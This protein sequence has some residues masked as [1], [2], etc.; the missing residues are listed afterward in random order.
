MTI[1]V[2]SAVGRRGVGWFGSLPLEEDSR[3][4]T[5]RQFLV[6]DCDDVKLQD[7]VYLAGLAAVIFRQN[8]EKPLQIERSLSD[9]AQRLLD[10]D[11]RVI[12]R[13]SEAG[14]TILENIVGKLRLPTAGLR[15]L[16]SGDPPLPHIRVFSGSVPWTYVA[17]FLLMYPPG[18]PPNP[19]LKIEP[20][21]IQQKLAGPR[22]IL[23][24][25]AFYDCSEIYLTPME[26][27]RSAGVTV[28][29]AHA[30]LAEGLEG[31][32][33]VPLFIKIGKRRKIF[34]EYQNYEGRVVPYIP[35]H[36]GPHLVR[37]RCCLGAN[38][39][40]IVGDFVD[41]SECLTDCAREGR[42][43]SAI[44]CLFDRTLAGWH[45]RARKEE[46]S[47][48]TLLA[49]IFPTSIPSARF[50]FAKALGA[51]QQ[52]PQLR[53]LFDRCTS[54][55]VLVGPVHGD[56]H[57]RNVR[58]RA[59]DAIVIDFFAHRDCPL[60]FDA[61]S[62]EASLLVE[63]FGKAKHDVN[64]WMKSV[65]ALY[66]QYPLEA[67]TPHPNPK[68]SSAWFYSCVRQI[69]RHAHQWEIHKRQ[70]AGALAAALLSKAAKDGNA[71]DPEGSRRAAAYVFAERILIAAFGQQ[72]ASVAPAAASADQVAPVAPAAPGGDQAPPAVPKTTSGQ[73]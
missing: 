40:V 50:A 12:I 72:G 33:P 38:V 11:C 56:L 28:Y 39:G 65:E 71:A 58:V 41:E 32:W 66:E 1:S 44:A 19:N 31:Q 27:G 34:A 14:L 25:R 53:G 55:P 18:A 2:L 52:L 48:A 24:R 7:A 59:T 22:D 47:I 57:A 61:A 46:S 36:L 21:A 9:H 63:G 20:P 8:P 17:D 37:D 43:S 45:R 51:T 26:G 5:E 4:F 69:R 10:H 60:L 70:Y 49:Q 54:A 64:E 6:S 23:L 30:E 68:N 16:P 42:A 73:P 62:L 3:A 67:E 35:F 15:P 13:P 29:R